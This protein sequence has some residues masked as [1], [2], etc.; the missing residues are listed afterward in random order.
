MTVEMSDTVYSINQYSSG[1]DHPFS[2]LS[3]IPFVSL[4]HPFWILFGIPFPRG[5][6]DSNGTFNW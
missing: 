4:Y 2:I 6:S 5:I 1:P 3:T